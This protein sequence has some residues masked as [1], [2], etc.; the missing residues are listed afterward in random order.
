MP[1]PSRLR[2]VGQGE[3][4]PRRRRG[5]GLAVLLVLLYA[6]AFVAA[7]WLVWSQTRR[8]R[9]AHPPPEPRAAAPLSDRR[10]L[11]A[12]DG[13]LPVRRVRYLRE[14]SRERCDCG[15]GQ[16]L[17][18]CLTKDEKCSRSP[19]LAEQLRRKPD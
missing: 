11:A 7:L 14:L 4:P 5:P 15:C 10:A 1:E 18:D 12:G 3:P 19:E 17:Q 6:L 9:G 8:E 13:L 2:I 16:T